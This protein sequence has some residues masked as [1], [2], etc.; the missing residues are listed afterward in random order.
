MVSEVR[1]LINKE[2]EEIIN[3]SDSLK[4]LKYYSLLYMNGA[5][6]RTCTKS[7]REYYTKLKIDGIM[8][9]ELY[10]EIKARTC[11][12]KWKGLKFIPS[13]GRHFSNEFITD[14]QATSLL[15]KGVLKESDFI[16]LPD[17]YLEEKEIEA[18]ILAEE[19]AAKKEEPKELK[20]KTKKKAK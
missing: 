10:E 1:E 7:Q 20:P 15:E 19:K 2:F 14:K 3:S 18:K 12:P 8:K 9:A 17:L 11:K 6:P 16:K 5:Q 4:L 13:Q